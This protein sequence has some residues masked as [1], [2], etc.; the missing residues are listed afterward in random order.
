MIR[1]PVSFTIAVAP[2]VRYCRV[3]AGPK[4]CR[5]RLDVVIEFDAASHT[6]LTVEGIVAER[7][8]ILIPL[9]VFTM[10][11]YASAKIILLITFIDVPLVT[12]A[13]IVRAL[14]KF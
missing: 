13:V 2:R 12:A 7:P 10:E 3:D 1:D 9:G 4:L 11:R 5:D 6:L 8:T 14:I